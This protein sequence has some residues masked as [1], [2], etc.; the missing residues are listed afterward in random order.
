ME[1]KELAV[2]CVTF[3]P[4]AGDDEQGWTRPPKGTPAIL[5]T[6]CPLFVRIFLTSSP[7]CQ[8]AKSLMSEA[9]QTYGKVSM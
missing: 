5:H 9:R 4:V 2:T 3:P 8:N 1:S 7:M 6:G